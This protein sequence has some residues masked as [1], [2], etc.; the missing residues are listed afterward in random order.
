M[1]SATFVERSPNGMDST[2]GRSDSKLDA[3][4]PPLKLSSRAA[5]ASV[6]NA[7]RRSTIEI[8]VIQDNPSFDDLG[9]RLKTVAIHLVS[10]AQ[11][12]QSH[13]R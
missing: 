9:K 2:A 6:T 11:Q 1:D 8:S 3:Y 12:F 4:R 13:L 10:N 5:S 7:T